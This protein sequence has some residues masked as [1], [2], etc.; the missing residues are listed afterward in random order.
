ME[1]M[2]MGLA[3]EMGLIAK[4]ERKKKSIFECVHDE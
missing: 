4:E 2:N 3:V 1:E